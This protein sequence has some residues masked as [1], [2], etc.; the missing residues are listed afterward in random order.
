M[1]TTESQELEVGDLGL[2]FPSL[3]TSISPDEKEEKDL[4]I[5]QLMIFKEK[6]SDWLISLLKINMVMRGFV[7]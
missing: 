4:L 2:L 3:P 7:I 6:D 1:T 5:S